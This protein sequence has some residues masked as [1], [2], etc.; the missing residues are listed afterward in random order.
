MGARKFSVHRYFNKSGASQMLCSFCG[1]KTTT[2]ATRMG[3]H[4]RKCIKCPQEI[5]KNLFKSSGL[6]G[7]NVII[8]PKDNSI[9]T[10]PP[11]STISESVPTESAESTT[12]L[13]S[14]SP[15]LYSFFR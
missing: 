4:I 11:A 1:W 14:H 13:D 15:N 7:Q 2:N 12:T 8:E 9:S 3:V 5:K 6:S 10:P